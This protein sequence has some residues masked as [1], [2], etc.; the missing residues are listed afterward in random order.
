MDGPRSRTTTVFLVLGFVLMALVF[1]TFLSLVWRSDGAVWLKLA[2]TAGLIAVIIAGSIRL[3]IASRPYGN[4]EGGE[5][6]AG[7]GT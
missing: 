4:P 1:L 3:T 7:N 6:V 5:R 2:A